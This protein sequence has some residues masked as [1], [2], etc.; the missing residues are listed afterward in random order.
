MA[1]EKYQ[2]VLQIRKGDVVVF[3]SIS[4]HDEP[5]LSEM[6][7]DMFDTYLNTGEYGTLIFTG[8]LGKGWVPAIFRRTIV[9]EK[10][11]ND[12][13][14]EIANLLNEWG[15]TLND[16]R[17]GSYTASVLNISRNKFTTI[18]DEEV[19][20]HSVIAKITITPRKITEKPIQS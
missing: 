9:D 7:T 10:A 12:K 19:E 5:H 11:M 4:V 2:H 18:V 20:V 14:Q 8:V 3:N 1:Y 16:M 13:K 6:N 15:V 17:G